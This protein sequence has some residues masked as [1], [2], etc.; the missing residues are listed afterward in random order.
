MPDWG[1]QGQPLIVTIVLAVAAVFVFILPAL[2]AGKWD[3]WLLVLSG[4]CGLGFAA[5]G[6]YEFEVFG[7]ISGGLAG[8]LVAFLVLGAPFGLLG[9]VSGAKGDER[10][11]DGREVENVKT[12]TRLLL[13]LGR[14]VGVLLLAASCHELFWAV[15]I[16]SNLAGMQVA[17]ELGELTAEEAELEKIA[18]LVQTTSARA[19]FFNVKPLGWMLLTQEQ[20]NVAVAIQLADYISGRHI[21]R[22]DEL[23]WPDWMDPTNAAALPG[24]DPATANYAQL[25]AAAAVVGRRLAAQ[26]EA[27]YQRTLVL[28]YIPRKPFEPTLRTAAGDESPSL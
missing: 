16:A 14:I 11:R 24:G 12:S 15:N 27:R 10:D 26:A 22:G 7:A 23:N 1:L 17:Q 21:E 20:E 2:S 25:N 19:R 28:R 3:G 18:S 5:W 8:A 6:Y 9:A 4:A 13:F